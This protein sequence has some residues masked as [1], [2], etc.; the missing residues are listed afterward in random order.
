V[1][2]SLP[3]DLG[4]GGVYNSPAANAYW[5]RRFPGLGGQASSLRALQERI[6][7]DANSRRF[8]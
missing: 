5:A 3:L 2:L 4:Y 8:P 7:A 6:N 1:A